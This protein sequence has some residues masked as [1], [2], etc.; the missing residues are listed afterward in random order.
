MQRECAAVDAE[1]GRK[2]RRLVHADIKH[3]SE[4]GEFFRTAAPG[5]TSF[6]LREQLDAAATRAFG[7]AAAGDEFSGTQLKRF[8]RKERKHSAHGGTPTTAG[9]NET[10]AQLRRS[11]G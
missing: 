10:A 8:E 9:N 6:S 5:Q 3:R 1:T 7:S 2:C 4:R 11:T